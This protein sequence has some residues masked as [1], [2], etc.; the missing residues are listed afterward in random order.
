MIWFNLF[1][2]ECIYFVH[3]SRKTLRTQK[4]EAESLLQI[5]LAENEQL[6]ARLNVLEQRY[7]RHHCVNVGLPATAY[8]LDLICLFVYGNSM[9]VPGKALRQTF[10]D[11]LQTL[12]VR[13]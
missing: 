3:L 7:E 5:C 8:H 2:I 4:E 13:N 11:K 12:Y 1:I 10:V 6:K 9:H